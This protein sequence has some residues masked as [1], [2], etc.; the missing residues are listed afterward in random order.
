[1]KEE[2]KL[3]CQSRLYRISDISKSLLNYFSVTDLIK[4]RKENY[5][6]IYEALQG[7]NITA[8]SGEG[9]FV[10][11]ACPVYMEDR[12]HF[13]Q[14]LAE[15]RVYCAVHW[16][17]EKAQLAENKETAYIAEHIISLPIDQRYGTE[18]MQ[19][20]QNLIENYK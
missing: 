8:A 14:Y 1:M 3:D 5:R 11:L 18:Q 7:K 20:V 17:L 2:H 4:K 12:D 13:R 15:K 10:P 6:I 9:P 19:Y 16:P